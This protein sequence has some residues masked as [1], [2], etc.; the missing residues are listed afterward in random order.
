MTDTAIAVT[1]SLAAVL[2]A[3]P[4]CL[5]VLSRDGRILFI[6]RCGLALMEAESLNAI[7]GSVYSDLW[8]EEC[9]Q[10]VVDAIDGAAGGATTSVEGYCPTLK[11]APRWW[12]T[13]FN[14]VKSQ[15]D[16]ATEIIAVT[17]DISARRTRELAMRNNEERFALFM[18]TSVDGI[19]ETAPDG[20]CTYINTAG[21]RMLGYQ[22]SEL[23]GHF[24][25]GKIHHHRA[26][27]DAYAVADCPIFK[28]A[29]AGKPRRVTDEVFWHKSGKAIPVDYSV[30]PIDSSYQKGGVVVAFTDC[31]EHRRAQR[32]LRRLTSELS[33]ADRRTNEFI[34][35]LAH[36]LRNPLA[37]IR[38]GLQLMR[39]AE[40]DPQAI[41]HVREMMERQLGQM[42]HLISDLLDIARVTSGKM[43]L[44]RERI[45][46]HQV[47][48]TAIEASASLIATANHSLTV[49]I[50]AEP[51]YIDG[52][53]TRLSQVFTNI[54][55]NAAK[56][57]SSGG[58]IDVR[59][60]RRDTQVIVKIIDTGIGIAADALVP[61][62]E[63][64]T[65][66]G[67]NLEGA[68][69]GLGIG[70][71]LV[72]RL[73][74]LHSGSVV[75]HSDGLGLGSHF[76]VTL[77]LAP[78]SED[79]WEAAEAPW[80]RMIAQRQ[81]VRV[82]LV[83][84]NVD[85]AAS[86][87]MLLQMGD[88]LTK[89]ANSGAEALRVI[90]EFRPDIVFLDIGMPGMNGYEVARAI[91]KMPEA[92]NPVLVALTGWGGELDRSRS[93]SAGFDEH[94]TKPADI[95]AIENLLS[96]LDQ[97]SHQNKPSHPNQP[98]I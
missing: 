23:V 11:G 74:E 59:V 39:K 9:R 87:S 57:T 40:D 60:A 36:E 21:A 46:L 81:G 45:E 22:S 50:P 72:R 30:Y 48:E 56:Y 16:G 29:H 66:V 80:K 55:D 76:V 61:I 94:L 67:R 14:S 28:A 84:D 3:S 42:V 12:E 69:G 41:G 89:V 58:K 85:A 15:P 90:A 91:R 68:Q 43:E 20:R 54:L 47:L 93:R 34:A 1:N 35:T 98:E 70:L 52:D 88:H 18:E 51:L 6:N 73:V 17:R 37:P 62:F 8:P 75:A 92:G 31:T 65:R 13:H 82:L 78:P 44:K 96:K 7:R 53:A 24:L 25:H 2:D 97:L 79:Y 4:D 10:S 19:C 95:S 71:N 33:D 86:L 49:D 26:D 64:F 38:T 5:K 27:G 77:P 32:D 83:D 63:M